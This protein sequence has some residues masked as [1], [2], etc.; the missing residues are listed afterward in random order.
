MHGEGCEVLRQSRRGDVEEAG[1]RTLVA[2]VTHTSWVMRSY[3]P[4]HSR[5]SVLFFLKAT[6]FGQLGESSRT[7]PST[8]LSPLRQ[9]LCILYTKDILL[10]L[11]SKRRI[12][13]RL[14]LKDKPSHQ[15]QDRNPYKPFQDRRRH[16]ADYQDL[17]E[18]IAARLATAWTSWVALMSEIEFKCR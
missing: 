5:T 13:S 7:S 3:S 14:L 10:T 18:Y 2:P 12:L 6:D 4:L 11:C 15:H 8:K 17:Y 9:T 1:S 16:V